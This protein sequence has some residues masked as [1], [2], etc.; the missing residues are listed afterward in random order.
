MHPKIFPRYYLLMIEMF[1]S[2]KDLNNLINVVNDELCNI[3]KR[4]KI[5]KLSL[6]QQQQKVHVLKFGRQKIK[7]NTDYIGVHIDNIVVV[8][9]PVQPAFSVF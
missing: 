9:M 1:Y 5:K 6:N 2:Q 4:F 3:A 8:L 7:N